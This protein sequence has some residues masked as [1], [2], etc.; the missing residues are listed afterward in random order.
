MSDRLA[1]L[2]RLA[3][4]ALVAAALA[5]PTT[6]MADTIRIAF[7]DIATV[8][9][10]HFLAAVER[11]KEKGVDVQMTFFK[12]EDVAAQA[13]VSGEA[14]VGVGTP[15]A[16]IQ[17]VKA[18][19]RVFLQL[20]TLRFYPIVNSEFY[21]TWKDLDGQEVA[22]H[23]RGSGTEAIMKLMAEREGIKYSNISYVP[24]AEVRAGALLQGNVK[25]SIVDSPNRNMLMEKAPGKFVVL[26][27][28][29]V[30]AS[31][32]ALYANTAFL[33]KNQ[34]AVDI[35]VESILQTWRDVQANPDVVVEWREKY[36]LLA[37]IPDDMAAEIKPYFKDLSDGKALPLNGG[38]E[39]AAKDDIAFYS[40]AGQIE[41]NPA[42]LDVATFWDVGPVNRALAKLGSQ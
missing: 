11:A 37:D 39:A 36:K 35:L 18:P 40:L 41:G 27:L 1:H 26:P 33:E 21:K 19:I 14:D 20:S 42:E 25:A 5:L 32:E 24:G 31:D 30:K 38:G 16:L 29:E 4:G 9:S 22:V 34:A 3:G 8:E 28:G 12:S 23:A 17:K 6:A 13:V 2:R 7:G 15:Y 10:L